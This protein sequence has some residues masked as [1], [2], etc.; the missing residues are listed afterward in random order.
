MVGKWSKAVPLPLLSGQRSVGMAK[1][2]VHPA[3]GKRQAGKVVLLSKSVQS[4]D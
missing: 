3:F 1:L 2:P 4:T